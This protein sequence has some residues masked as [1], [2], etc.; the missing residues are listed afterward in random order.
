MF[1]AKDIHVAPVSAKVGRAAVLKWH[2]SGKYNNNTQLWL[3]AFLNGVLVGVMG[4]GCSMD[5]HKI[6]GLVAGTGME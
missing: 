6:Q 5:K 4:F 2:Y 3:G 1:T